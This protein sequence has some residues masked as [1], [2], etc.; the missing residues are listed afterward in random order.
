MKNRLIL[1]IPISI[2]I[3]GFILFY[4]IIN[5]SEKPHK[6]KEVGEYTEL[7]FMRNLGNEAENRAYE[8]LVSAFEAAHPDIRIN[9]EAVGYSDYEIRL[10]TEFATGNPPD[11]VTIDSPTL[12]LYVNADSLLPLDKY[13]EERDINDFPKSIMNGLSYNGELYLVPIVESS[14][15]LFYNMHIFRETGIP[16]P[17]KDPDNPLT[18][19]EI[20]D[21]AIQVKNSN[22]D[23]Y[24]IDPAQGF[25]DGESPA[26]FKMPILWQF[27]ADILSPNG[28]TASGYLDSMEAITALQFYQDL[29]NKY[30]VAAVELPTHSFETGQLAMTVLGSWALSAIANNHPD[31]KLGRDYGIAPL[32]KGKYQVTPNGGWALGISSKTNYPDEAWQFIKFMTSFESAKTYVEVTGDLPARYS[33]VENFPELNEY[34]KNIF[35]HQFQNNSKSRPVTPVYPVISDNIKKLFENVGIGNR[36]VEDSVKEAVENINTSISLYQKP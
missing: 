29:Y 34:P 12:A 10:R 17:S 8:M 4:M 14:I 20:L 18:W 24:G 32:P 16:F 7:T 9:M 3:I 30:E 6:N 5:S 13:M 23:L 31:F 11:I 22:N 15:A 1:I 33:V 21:I 25:S 36:D 2:S 26:Y 27:G 19:E 35:I 28:T